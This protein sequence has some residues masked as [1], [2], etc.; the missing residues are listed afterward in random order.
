[1]KANKKREETLTANKT[2][3]VLGRSNNDALRPLR[4]KLLEL[5]Q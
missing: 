5:V 4:I 2:K 1:M 3:F